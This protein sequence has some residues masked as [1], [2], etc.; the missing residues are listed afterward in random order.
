[1]VILAAALSTVVV[2]TLIALLVLM[3]SNVG[4]G[5]AGEDAGSSADG[6][7][8]VG[9][10]TGSAGGSADEEIGGA[11]NL[12]HDRGSNQN[13]KPNTA[14][15]PLASSK[16]PT[17]GDG[18]DESDSDEISPQSTK[19]AYEFYSQR[20]TG[21]PPSGPSEKNSG[22]AD[23]FGVAESGKRFVYVV[24]KSSSMT[25]ERFENARK[26]L[27]KSIKKLTPS[28]SF[29]IVF[30]DTTSYPQPISKLA[31]ATDANIRKMSTWAN[32]AIPNGGTDPM[33]AIEMA[34]RL[35]PDAIF[36]LSDGEFDD[37]IVDRT[38]MLNAKK[39]VIKINTIGFQND[40]E[41]LRAIAERNHGAYRFV[42]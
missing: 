25:G 16:Q 13:T 5:T 31:Q 33:E 12:R 42:P 21:R 40:A 26:E 32:G 8:P 19:I 39:P 9:D 7:S 6:N 11:P 2:F 1:L 3:S 22:K 10:G 41:T 23:F 38:T 30:Y 20:P 28:Q 17:E 29:F 27:L 15:V 14:S 18:T 37:S 35:K 24:D 4:T 34:L 36:I